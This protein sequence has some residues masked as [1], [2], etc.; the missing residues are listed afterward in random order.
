MALHRGMYR[1]ESIII[2]LRILVSE[3]SVLSMIIAAMQQH[4]FICSALRGAI[5]RINHNVTAKLLTQ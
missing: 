4:P 5:S 1:R 3:G 2:L